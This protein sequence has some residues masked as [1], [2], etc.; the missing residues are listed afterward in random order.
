MAISGNFSSV[1]QSTSKQPPAPLAFPDSRHK[2]TDEPKTAWDPIASPQGSGVPDEMTVDVTYD[3][4]SR[5][6]VRTIGSM[7]RSH[8]A[9]K[10]AQIARSSVFVDS[11]TAQYGNGAGIAQGAAQDAAAMAHRDGSDRFINP[12]QYNP[13]P[14]QGEG[15]TRSIDTT[16]GHGDAPMAVKAIARN[17]YSF[18]TTTGDATAQVTGQRMPMGR[19]WVTQGYSSP[20]LGGMYSSNTLRGIRPQVI[21][22][23]TVTPGIGGTRNSGI[24][25]NK[26]W[27]STT[28]A[29][30]LMRRVPPS[31]SDVQLASQTQQTGYS[32]VETW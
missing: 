24:P 3:P 11:V 7:F 25:G 13:T 22:T 16:A 32:D 27:I 26:P 4:L 12:Q 5:G 17:G 14:K 10:K 2:K 18:V 21:N 6:I 29:T 23:P 20:A 28:V 19:N 1:Y 31:P 8:D 30:P 9:S 15:D